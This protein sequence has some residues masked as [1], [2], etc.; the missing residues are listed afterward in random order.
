MTPPITGISAMATR[1]VLRDLAGIYE[2][3]ASPPLCALAPSTAVAPPRIARM[4]EQIVMG[5]AMR[6]RSLSAPAH[7][8]DSRNQ[9]T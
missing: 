3:R 8:V 1:G 2:A 5:S 4:S 9:L 6:H 7:N